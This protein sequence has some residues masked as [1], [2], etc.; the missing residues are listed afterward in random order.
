MKQFKKQKKF[1]RLSLIACLVSIITCL[2]ACGGKPYYPEKIVYSRPEIPVSVEPIQESDVET[3]VVETPVVDE[4]QG[5]ENDV[6]TETP[7]AETEITETTSDYAFNSIEAIS[8]ICG[9]EADVE[10]DV[11]LGYVN[12]WDEHNPY[13]VVFEYNDLYDEYVDACDWSL[14]FDV[15][16]YMET[17]PMLAMQYHYD[18]ELLLEHF[19]TRGIQEGRQGS[20]DFNVG[21]YVCNSEAISFD[22]FDKNFEG[23]YFY[24]MLNYETEKNVNTVTRNSGKPVKIQYKSVLTAMQQME[25]H[26]INEYRA[27]VGLEPYA[28]NDEVAAIA[29]YRAYN[30]AVLDISGHDWMYEH[31]YLINEW[32]GYYGWECFSENT[33]CSTGNT[34]GRTFGPSYASSEAHYNAMISTKYTDCGTSLVFNGRNK[35]NY[36][37]FDCFIK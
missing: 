35:W 26:E 20:A 33:A 30:N 23:Y 27:E 19:Q 25:F 10:N 9:L 3:P 24:Y 22:A 13:D 34:N 2:S 11:D 29:C 6:F 17:F 28:W 8:E 7:D 18:E 12:T 1:R 15:D 5:E 4:T 16:Y 31:E 36:D 21:A 32:C 14:V 37:Q